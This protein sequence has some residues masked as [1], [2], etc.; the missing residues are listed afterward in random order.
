MFII[1]GLYTI[2]PLEKYNKNKVVT[3]SRNKILK[4]K[5]NKLK[6]IGITGSYGKTSTKVFT[7]QLLAQSY[8]SY[9]TPKS[10]NTLWGI[11]LPVHKSGIL[12]TVQSTL[13]YLSEDIEYF[14]VEMGAYFYGE[15]STLCN[16]FPPDIVIL[17]GISA[18]HLE[19]FKTIENIIKAKS[20]ILY[21][22]RVVVQQL[23]MLTTVIPERLSSNHPVKI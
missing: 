21:G 7:D 1:L 3:I 14:L 6:V 22:I 11:A 19:R 17:T 12:N 15:I 13:N 18:V 5:S 8:T 4:L 23:L 10:Y 2:I 16:A 9:A 20:E